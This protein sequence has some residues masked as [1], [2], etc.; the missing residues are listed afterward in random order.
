M[1]LKIALKVLLYTF[2]IR[3]LKA[4]LIAHRNKKSKLLWI[5]MIT[6]PT[7]H[8]IRFTNRSKTTFKNHVQKPRSK[9]HNEA[10]YR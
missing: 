9:T 7:S 10:V 3:M 5:A 8:S 1:V 4:I 2:L 6:I